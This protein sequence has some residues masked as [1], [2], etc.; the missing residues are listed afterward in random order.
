MAV[1][2]LGFNK[3]KLYNKATAHCLD[4]TYVLI[5]SVGLAVKKIYA[6]KISNLCLDTIKC[7]IIGVISSLCVVWEH[8]S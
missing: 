1:E 2:L 5:S 3:V 6:S 8:S 4:K 7:I